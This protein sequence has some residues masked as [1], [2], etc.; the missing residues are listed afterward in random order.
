MEGLRAHKLMFLLIYSQHVSA[1]RGHHQAIR[2]EYTNDDR[3][4]AHYS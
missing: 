4:H 2:G 1:Q 3:S